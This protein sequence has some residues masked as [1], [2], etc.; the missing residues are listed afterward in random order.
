MKIFILSNA[1]NYGGSERSIE[2]LASELSTNDSIMVFAENDEHIKN[3]KS[4]KINVVSLKKGKGGLATILNIFNIIKNIGFDGIIIA[5]TNKAAF[6]MAL[7]NKIGF[8]RNNRK[9][10]FVRDFQWQHR[11]FIKKNILHNNIYCMPSEACRDYVSF[12]SENPRIIPDPICLV[13]TDSKILD[14][15]MSNYIVCPAMISRWKG[16]DLLVKAF[17]LIENDIK[18]VVVGKV[19][20]VEFYQEVKSLIREYNLEHKI[21]FL[22]FTSDI[23]VIYKNSLFVV[24]SSVSNFGGPETFGR[25]I[26]EAWQFKKTI[27]SFKCGGPKYLID[28]KKDGILVDEGDIESFAKSIDFLVEN[29][30][31]RE[32]M[33]EIGMRK[34]LSNFSSTKIVNDLRLSFD[35]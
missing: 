22:K 34:S 9:L 19:L 12:F 10:I 23:D 30:E 16:I 4:R 35:S 3:L 24:N 32:A 29:N 26:I 11:S 15:K 28:H 31:I 18:L 1:S 8:L 13:D 6:Y 17:H 7:I 21:I 27:I 33:G 25:T 2:L 20:D 5:N 14:F